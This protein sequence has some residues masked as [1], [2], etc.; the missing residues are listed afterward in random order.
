MFWFMTEAVCPKC[1]PTEMSLPCPKQ[2][3]CSV[4]NWNLQNHQLKPISLFHKQ[5]QLGFHWVMANAVTS[6]F[7][8]MWVKVHV[9][10]KKL[11]LYNPSLKMVDKELLTLPRPG[12]SFDKSAQ[13]AAPYAHNRRK[14]QYSVSQPWSGCW[15]GDPKQWRAQQVRRKICCVNSQMEILYWKPACEPAWVC[16]KAN[17]KFWNLL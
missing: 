1:T 5:L 8:A 4:L 7:C 3:S 17:Y 15:H 6:W 13:V 16:S 9:N 12:I 11:T 14:V 2:W 10:R